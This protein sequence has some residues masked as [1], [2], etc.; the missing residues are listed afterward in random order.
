MRA[1]VLLVG[2]TR[3]YDGAMCK[4]GTGQG[5]PTGDLASNG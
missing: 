1:T 3:L 5:Y 2:G 4:L